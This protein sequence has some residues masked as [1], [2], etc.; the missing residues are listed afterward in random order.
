MLK[1]IET[2]YAFILIYVYVQEKKLVSQ[3]IDHVAFIKTFLS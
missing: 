1:V 2:S 3:S